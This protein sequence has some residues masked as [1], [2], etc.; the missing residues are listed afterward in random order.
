MITEELIVELR[1]HIFMTGSQENRI[2]ENSDGTLDL[3][4]HVDIIDVVRGGLPFKIR[5]SMSYV[6]VNAGLTTLEGSPRVCER[7]N[8]SQNKLTSLVGGP[9]IVEAS[10]G[11]ST[12]EQGAAYYSCRNNPLTSLEGLPN[13]IGGGFLMSYNKNTPMLRLVSL[14]CRT[15]VLVSE[16]EQNHDHEKTKEVESIIRLNFRRLQ[17]GMITKKES[18]WQCSQGLIEC[19]HNNNAKW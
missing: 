13:R 1:K 16:S 9:E 12:F 4:F 7:F 6:A 14:G 3:N 5:K 17:E 2:T 11:A 8:I 15:I 10:A 18:I 19:G